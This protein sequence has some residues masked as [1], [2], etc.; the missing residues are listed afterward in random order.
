MLGAQYAADA[1]WLQDKL[2]MRGDGFGF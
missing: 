1:L 2:H